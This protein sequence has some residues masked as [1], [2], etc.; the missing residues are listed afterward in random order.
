[1]HGAGLRT[2][3]VRTGER[4]TRRHHPR[5]R[6]LSPCGNTFAG[7]VL[8]LYAA[9]SAIPLSTSAPSSS[10]REARAL[11]KRIVGELDVQK[12][13]DR[14]RSDRDFLLM[15][16]P[17][18]AAYGSRA[19]R[20]QRRDGSPTTTCRVQLHV[21]GK[22]RVSARSCCPP[23]SGR[24][25]SRSSRVDRQKRRCSPPESGVRLSRQ[26]VHRW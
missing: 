23:I 9:R 2:G 13:I 26:A 8:P 1:M 3:T 20:P 14:C 15:A 25:S 17:T 7:E 16:W 24:S 5:S 11:S 10:R 19:G 12:L 22:G 4:G 6:R 18:A 21:L